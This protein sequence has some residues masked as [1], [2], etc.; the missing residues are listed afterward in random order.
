MGGKVQDY[1]S[2]LVIVHRLG[3]L[4]VECMWGFLVRVQ[5]RLMAL[6]CD[7]SSV[8]W[9]CGERTCGIPIAWTRG[10][11]VELALYS[12]DCW[13]IGTGL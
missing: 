11:V 8:L 1:I 5:T 10:W 12:H 6:L 13:L 4:V 2:L 3:D 7:Y 9:L